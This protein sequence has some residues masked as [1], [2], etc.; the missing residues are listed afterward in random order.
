LDTETEILKDDLSLPPEVNYLE[1][2]NDISTHNAEDKNYL[3]FI[4]PILLTVFLLL[5]TLSNLE[6]KTI[7]D[8]GFTEIEKN[9]AHSNFAINILSES[10]LSAGIKDTVYTDKDCWLELRIDQQMLYQHWRNGNTEKYAISSGDKNKEKGVES[11]PGLFAIFS[12]EEHHESSQFDNADMYYFMPFNMGIGLHSL[13]GTGYYGLLGVRPASH[14]CIRMRHEDVKK[15][16]KE[17][18]LGTIVLAHRGYT[19]RTIGF[20]PKDFVNK[21]EYS[22]DEFKKM[23]AENLANILDG[24]FY[25]KERKYFVIDPKIIPVSGIYISYDRKI[26]EKQKLNR[27]VYVFKNKSDVVA[28]K[29]NN[30]IIKNEENT[31]EILG[32]LN[33]ILINEKDLK[34]NISTNYLTDAE[35]IKKFFH[36]PIGILPYFPPD[37]D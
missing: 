24:N 22:K 33:D 23:L 37:K 27:N 15:L 9:T 20:A 8:S 30:E 11:R 18:P 28:L 32:L 25:T 2:L 7:S 31:D 4:F 17:C 34:K 36:N 1:K 21:E 13:D 14:G 35:L 26:P 5:G 10:D 3:F 12:K 19:A 29:E 16:F 6:S